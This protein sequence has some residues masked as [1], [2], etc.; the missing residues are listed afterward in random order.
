[1]QRALAHRQIQLPAQ[2]ATLD[3]AAQDRFQ[4]KFLERRKGAFPL[5]VSRVTVDYET[6]APVA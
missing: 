6:D 3:E 2:K 4:I 1:M 5:E